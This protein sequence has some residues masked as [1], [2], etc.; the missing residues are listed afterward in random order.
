MGRI[1]SD[2]FVKITG[3]FK[4][5]YKLENGKYVVPTL[6]E[7]DLKLSGFVNQAF[8]YGDNRLYNVALIVPDFD[9]LQEWAKANN[10][11]DQSPDALARNPQCH[12]RIGEEI[13]RYSKEWKGYERVQK[14]ALLTEEFS[15]ANDMMTP[16]MSVKRRNVVARYQ[17]TLDSLY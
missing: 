9:A 16:K 12:A 6:L 7:E 4:E 8:V 14:W 17:D 15:T 11:S 5:Q 13:A 1:T 10:I 2:G 3:R